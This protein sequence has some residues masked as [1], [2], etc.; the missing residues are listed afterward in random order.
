MIDFQNASFSKPRP[1]SPA[2][3][4]SMI[5]PKF[6]NEEHDWR[7]FPRNADVSALCRVIDA[8]LL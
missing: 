8:S 7:R 4:K 6:V 1:V 2:T 3:F 5:A